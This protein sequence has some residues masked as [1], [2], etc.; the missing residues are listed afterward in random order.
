MVKNINAI[1]AIYFCHIP[2]LMFSSHSFVALVRDT[3]LIFFGIITGDR[4]DT[5]F[6]FSIIVSDAEIYTVQF[7]VYLLS[8]G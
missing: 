7:L 3:S 8:F 4:L 6:M 2:Y 5:T 1:L